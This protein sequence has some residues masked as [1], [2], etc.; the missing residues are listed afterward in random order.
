MNPTSTQSN[1]P[2][3]DP[4]ALSLWRSIKSAEGGSYDN[5][6]GDNG[7]SAGVGQWNNGKIA[8]KK[9]EIPANFKSGASQF[10]LDPNDFS[11]VNQD[12]VGYS[13]VEKDLKDGL[14]QSSIAAK[15]NSG[16]THG[17]EN[18]VGDTTI[19]GKTVHYDT[20][21]YVAKVQKAYQ[22]QVNNPQ[23]STNTTSP[24]TT[25]NTRKTFSESIKEGKATQPNA[26][27]QAGNP[28]TGGGKLGEIVAAVTPG[29][30]LAQGLGYGLASA[31]GSQKGLIEA[32]GNNIDIQGQLLKQI[33]DNKAKGKDT[34]RL[35][36]ALNQLG[37]DI[38]DEGN[39][40]SDVGTGGITNKEV[41]K[42]AGSLATLPALAYAGSAI[43]A[44][45]L[46]KEG[47]GLYK[48]FSMGKKVIP[49]I[50]KVAP[51][52]QTAINSSKALDFSDVLNKGLSLKD[53]VRLSN[54]E[55]LKLLNPTMQESILKKFITEAPQVVKKSLLKTGLKM[56]GGMLG[57]EVLRRTVGP[58]IGGV[59]KGLIN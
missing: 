9:G 8:L 37:I 14:S 40:V 34:S 50:E 4:T 28:T 43:K 7:T 42:S 51:E 5:T 1:T 53:T 13:Q 30:K 57:G 35:E 10:G 48:S 2:Q 33:K 39:Q 45:N 25:S 38:K 59:I 29:N 22:D 11:E 16:L 31:T 49:L 6:S 54:F 21:A 58:K 17:W 36:K 20:P 27:L 12:H 18:H 47:N 52:I 26:D 44:G 32:Q 55:K 24:S 56:G 41:L 15:W 3:V 46:L 19:N 23:S